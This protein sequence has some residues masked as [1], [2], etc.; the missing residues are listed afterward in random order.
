MKTIIKLLIVLAILNAVARAGLAAVRYYQFKDDAQQLVTFGS[1][2]TPNEI[3]NHILEKAEGL[4]L[5]VT[6]EDISVTRDGISTI[7]TASYT[8]AIEVFPRYQ[9]PFT[10]QLTVT[11]IALGRPG[12]PAPAAN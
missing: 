6:Y 12:Q 7:A 1:D 8:Q 11:G 5:P 2:A 9:Y 3:Q 10:F 4:A